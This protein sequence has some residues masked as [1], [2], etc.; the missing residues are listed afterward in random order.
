[1]QLALKNFYSV[2]CR[3]TKWQLHETYRPIY[4]E[5]DNDYW[6]TEDEYVKFGTEVIGVSTDFSIDDS[7]GLRV[8]LH[9][10][11]LHRRLNF[12]LRL[13]DIPYNQNDTIKILLFQTNIIHTPCRE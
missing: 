11:S 5:Y 12:Y 4:F 1:M 9:I 3:I 2:E 8:N 10:P 6:A 13:H 7:R